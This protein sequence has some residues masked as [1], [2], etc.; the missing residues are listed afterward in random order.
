VLTATLQIYTITAY[1]VADHEQSL[2]AS[3][4]TTSSDT[5]TIQEE[6]DSR[7][8]FTAFFFNYSCILPA[9]QST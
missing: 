1:E 9:S 7:R 3:T 6:A 5:C 4:D 8:R 2:E